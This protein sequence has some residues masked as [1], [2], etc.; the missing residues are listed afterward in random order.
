MTAYYQVIKTHSITLGNLH[1]LMY[2]ILLKIYRYM[3]LI[4]MNIGISIIDY[5][6]MANAHDIDRLVYIS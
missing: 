6:S 1:N 4:I 3:R 5:L 2:N